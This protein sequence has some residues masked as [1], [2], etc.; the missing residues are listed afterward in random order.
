MRELADSLRAQYGPSYVIEQL[1]NQAKEKNEDAIL[2]SVR[3]V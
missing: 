3:T 1:Y 2:E